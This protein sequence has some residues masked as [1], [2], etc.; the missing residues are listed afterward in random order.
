[1]DWKSRS[2]MVGLEKPIFAPRE[3]NSLAQVGVSPLTGTG[4]LWLWVPQAKFEQKFQFGEKTRL[5]AQ[6][7][8]I[9]THESL[10]LQASSYSPQVASSAR[11][12]VEGRFEFSHGAEGGRRIEIAPGFHFSETHVA[13]TSVASNLVSADWFFNPLSKLEF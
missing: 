5:R 2:F 13:D 11:P 6:V 7:G 3:P 4:N 9:A 1:I 10:A 12:G 8:M